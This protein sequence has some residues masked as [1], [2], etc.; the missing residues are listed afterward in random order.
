M[1]KLAT[2]WPSRKNTQLGCY[3]RLRTA[4]H[5]AACDKTT[6][7]AN[8][9]KVRW[10]AVTATIDCIFSHGATKNLS[11]KSEVRSA[12]KYLFLHMKNSEWEFSWSSNSVA[13]L[14]CEL[15]FPTGFSTTQRF[16]GIWITIQLTIL[17][18]S[19]HAWLEGECWDRQSKPV[20]WGWVLLIEQLL[21]CMFY[22]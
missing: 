6:S 2:V 20:V 13:F 3:A 11:L 15:V 14:T 8:N 21:W 22:L 12:D 5:P 7:F 10:P 16:W 17:N 19:N 9:A 1:Y 18:N 4:I